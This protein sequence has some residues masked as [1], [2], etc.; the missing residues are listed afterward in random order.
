MLVDKIELH[1]SSYASRFLLD[2]GYFFHQNEG[3]VLLF[4]PFEESNSCASILEK[5]FSC[6]SEKSIILIADNVYRHKVNEKIIAYKRAFGKYDLFGL[7][8][9]LIK[10]KDFSMG[11]CCF[12]LDCAVVRGKMD[13]RII[14]KMIDVHYKGGYLYVELFDGMVDEKNAEIY[15]DDC[16]PRLKKENP[17]VKLFF[18]NLL[19][20]S[21]FFA[22]FGNKDDLGRISK[23]LDDSC[24]TISDDPYFINS[25]TH[26]FP[27]PFNIKPFLRHC[28]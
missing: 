1:S 5:I 15:F 4:M 23:S 6:F 2:E 12:F 13:H 19:N 28:K 27:L 16:F 24:L 21:R 9:L 3:D 25:I 10:K 17:S 8:E 22:F 26:F 20:G 14:T 18:G 11:K 7:K